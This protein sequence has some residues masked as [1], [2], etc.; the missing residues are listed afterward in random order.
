MA[1]PIP[2]NILNRYRGA[3]A[4]VDQGTTPS[5]RS[6]AAGIVYQMEEKYPGIRA[7]AYPPPPRQDVPGFDAF[8]PSDGNFGGAGGEA[9]KL[10]WR[11][12][13]REQ[14]E[15]IAGD[16]IRY[17][18]SRDFERVTAAAA[19][20][21]RQ[22]QG[23]GVSIRDIAER[24]TEIQSKTLPSGKYQI[25]MKFDVDDLTH[26]LDRMNPAQTTEFVEVVTGL[27]RDQLIYSLTPE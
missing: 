10:D 21:A 20:A 24:I 2:E 15:K 19:E 22:Q 6:T 5:E 26:W 9:S 27:F 23:I 14:A 1:Q 13:L 11:K 18:A 7:Q 4:R 8:T 3:K 17:A 16:A 25:A 12:I